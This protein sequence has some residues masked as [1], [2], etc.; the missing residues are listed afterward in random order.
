MW[1]RAARGV[2]LSIKANGDLL[3]PN[4]QVTGRA[5]DVHRA[6]YGDVI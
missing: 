4:G 5:A 3:I 1:Y 2:S 6:L